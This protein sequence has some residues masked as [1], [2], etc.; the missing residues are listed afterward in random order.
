M[1]NVYTG[2]W[3]AGEGE[4]GA[5]VKVALEAG[6]RHIDGAWKYDVSATNARVGEY[7]L[8]RVLTTPERGGGRAGY[9]GE[10]CGPRGYLV[11]VQGE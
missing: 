11:D 3:Q 4:V 9:Q 5:A 1:L 6:Y 10:R 8:K 7:M 2:V